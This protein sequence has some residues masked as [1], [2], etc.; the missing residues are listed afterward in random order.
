MQ[1]T[2]LVIGVATAL[3]TAVVVVFVV[4]VLLV[5]VEGGVVGV[6]ALKSG[7][8]ASMRFE[9]AAGAPEVRAGLGE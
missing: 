1:M 3:V 4:L 7:E 6:L 8:A 5:G 2:G 9:G